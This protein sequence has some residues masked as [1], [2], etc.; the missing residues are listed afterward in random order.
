MVF[1]S[2]VHNL[3]SKYVVKRSGKM[4]MLFAYYALRGL[5]TFSR[6]STIFAEEMFAY[7][8]TKLILK[9]N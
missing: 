6:L 2:R 4:L 5:N 8:Y 3:L 7:L 1:L 9:K